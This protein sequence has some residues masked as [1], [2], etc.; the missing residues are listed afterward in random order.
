MSSVF[1]APNS[2]TTTGHEQETAERCERLNSVLENG[3]VAYETYIPGIDAHRKPSSA[4]RS[5]TMPAR[6]RCILRLVETRAHEAEGFLT[7]FMITYG[8]TSSTAR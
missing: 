1:S 5:P 8:P 7:L 2:R 4:G 3:F 6:R